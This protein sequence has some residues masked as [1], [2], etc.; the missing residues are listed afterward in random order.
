MHKPSITTWPANVPVIVL[1][2]PLA[3]SAIANNGLAAATP[4]SGARVK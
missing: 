4:S 1:A 3:N 2:W